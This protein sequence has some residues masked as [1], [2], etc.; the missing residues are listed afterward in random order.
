VDL[1]GEKYIYSTLFVKINWSFQEISSIE[2]SPTTPGKLD[3]KSKT[4]VRLM[5]MDEASRSGTSI[6]SS[7]SSTYSAPAE[8]ETVRMERGNSSNSGVELASIYEVNE[9]KEK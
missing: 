8:L 2:K 9:A 4:K 3:K 6:D 7:T 5:K 1:Q